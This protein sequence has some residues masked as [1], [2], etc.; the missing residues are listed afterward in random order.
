MNVDGVHHRTVRLDG[1][2]VDLIDQPRLPHAFARVRTKT[3]LETC[4]SLIVPGTVLLF[5]EF[6]LPG[7]DGVS[8]DE[9][10]AFH[11]WAQAH[12]RQFQFLWRTRWVQCAIRI[13][14]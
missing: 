14:R 11:E 4:N 13:L 7:K 12:D 8:D 6:F 1:A 3:V 10:R 2:C 5:D 9:C